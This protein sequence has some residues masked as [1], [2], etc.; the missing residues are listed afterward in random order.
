[1]R[2]ASSLPKQ[3]IDKTSSPSTFGLIINLD[4]S[5]AALGSTAAANR[6]SICPAGPGSGSSACTVTRIDP[7]GTG[8]IFTTS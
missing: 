2:D 5:V 4:R 3:I 6:Y 7:A 8:D 1:M